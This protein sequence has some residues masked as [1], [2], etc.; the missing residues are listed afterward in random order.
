VSWSGVKPAGSQVHAS[1]RVRVSSDEGA[2]F[3]V[4]NVAQVEGLPENLTTLP[5]LAATTA[6]ESRGYA[7]YLPVA[8]KN[9]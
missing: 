6:V 1:F 9:H 3:D 4:Q 7:V 5:T 8:L 2:P